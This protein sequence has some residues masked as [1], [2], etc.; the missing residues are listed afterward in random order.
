TKLPRNS[1]CWSK[2][3]IQALS[4]VSVFSPSRAFIHWALA[5]TNSNCPSKTFHTVS[6]TPRSTPW[7]HGLP[8][9][10][11]AIPPAAVTRA[12]WSRTASDTCVGVL[13]GESPRRL[14]P[15]SC[16]HPDRNNADALLPWVSPFCQS[17]RGCG[18]DKEI[19][20][21]ARRF[22]GRHSSLYLY[23]IPVRF[24]HGLP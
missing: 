18:P 5:S 14:P 17:R 4:L 11:S 2:S 19:P 7:P 3:A 23:R 15:F 16:E 24:V 8:R 20:S 10:L 9:V 21:R 6:S 12:K 22:P 1:P 13:A